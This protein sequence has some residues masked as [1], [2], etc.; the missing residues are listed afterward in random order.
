VQAA[1]QATTPL[2]LGTQQ[3][4]ETTCSMSN[5]S[6]GLQ[7]QHRHCTSAVLQSYERMRMLTNYGSN[8]G[9]CSMPAGGPLSRWHQHSEASSWAATQPPSKPAIAAN[10]VGAHHC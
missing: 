8:N 6:A 1:W 10:I 2:R 5:S 7:K 4:A 9:S 3:T